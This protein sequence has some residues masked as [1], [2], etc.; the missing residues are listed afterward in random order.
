VC[1]NYRLF[2]IDRR[3]CRTTRSGSIARTSR[4]SFAAT[5]VCDECACVAGRLYT[6]YQVEILDVDHAQRI[7]LDGD[8][9]PDLRRVGALDG[10]R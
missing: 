10:S 3:G 8:S 7:E 6:R 4:D 5:G 9:E 1:V 2:V